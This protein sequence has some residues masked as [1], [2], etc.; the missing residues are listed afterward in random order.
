M[1]LIQTVNSYRA[2]LKL[3]QTI[4]LYFRYD[5]IFHIILHLMDLFVNIQFLQLFYFSL[6]ALFYFFVGILRLN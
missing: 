3:Y 2:V 6:H 4:K 5:A 1:V